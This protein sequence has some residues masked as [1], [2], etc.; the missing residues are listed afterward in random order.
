[1]VVYAMQTIGITDYAHA[2]LLKKS[3]REHVQK[4]MQLVLGRVQ[5]YEEHEYG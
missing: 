1:M 2:N 4:G 5:R 3:M